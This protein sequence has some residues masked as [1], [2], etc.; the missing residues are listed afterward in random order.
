MTNLEKLIADS[1]WEDVC[2][3]VG[4]RYKAFSGYNTPDG[5][6]PCCDPYETLY[7]PNGSQLTCITEPEDRTFYRDLSV[8]VD[9]LNTLDYQRQKLAKCAE[10]M[11]IGL[12]ALQKAAAMRGHDAEYC[13]IESIWREIETALTECEKIAGCE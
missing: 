13:F 10:V 9:E 6:E 5:L 3:K 4:R 1:E 11:R 7:R 2:D 12:E 8:I